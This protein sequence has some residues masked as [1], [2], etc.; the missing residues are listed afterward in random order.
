MADPLPG[1]YPLVLW[2]GDTR[3]FTVEFAEDDS[4]VDLS[5]KTWTSEIRATYTSDNIDAEIDVDDTDAATGVLV[6]TL[7]A[8]QANL[9]PGSYVWDLQ[10]EDTGVVHTWLSGKVKV[11]GDVT[12]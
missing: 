7:T 5:G 8:D 9:D 2:R 6:L 12:R 11:K 4:P 3:T 10:S 1:T